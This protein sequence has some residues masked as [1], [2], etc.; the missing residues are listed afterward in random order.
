MIRKFKFFEGIDENSYVFSDLNFTTLPIGQNRTLRTYWTS[1]MSQDLESSHGI[2]AESELTR[3]LSGE[4]ARTIDE[5]IVTELTRR[6]NG[7]NRA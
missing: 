5:N 1:E 2:D 7:G 4:I 6:I 3:F